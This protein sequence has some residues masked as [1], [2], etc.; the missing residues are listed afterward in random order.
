MI[1]VEQARMAARA[2]EGSNGPE[3]MVGVVEKVEL[4]TWESSR[5]IMTIIEH[6][7][8]QR[9]CPFCRRA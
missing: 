2:A 1:V 9:T 7:E 8:L 5:R 3:R 4:A 6:K